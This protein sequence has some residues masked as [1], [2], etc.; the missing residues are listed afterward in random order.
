MLED[1]FLLFVKST[2]APLINATLLHLIP[3]NDECSTYILNALSI[4]KLPLNLGLQERGDSDSDEDEAIDDGQEFEIE[5]IQAELDQLLQKAHSHTLLVE[6]S[7]G[8]DPHAKEGFFSL[9]ATARWIT[10]NQLV[11][12]SPKKEIDICI[13]NKEERSHLSAKAEMEDL[14]A[15][16]VI[17]TERGW[18]LKFDRRI[19]GKA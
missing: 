15:V 9:R 18:D 8:L 4:L 11:R 2:D 13:H 19:G 6:Y 1:V 5:G 16:T 7:V 3:P 12:L 14:G 17:Q 10:F